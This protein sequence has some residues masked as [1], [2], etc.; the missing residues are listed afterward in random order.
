MDVALRQFAR[1]ENKNP[2]KF[3]SIRK[4]SAG[5]YTFQERVVVNLKYGS[6]ASHGAPHGGRIPF[7]ATE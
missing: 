4:I 5:T 3:G 6:A 1:E 2:Q 7:F